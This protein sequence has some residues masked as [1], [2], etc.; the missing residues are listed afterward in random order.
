LAGIL[1]SGGQRQLI[2]DRRHLERLMDKEGV[3]T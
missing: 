2:R 3:R 1:A